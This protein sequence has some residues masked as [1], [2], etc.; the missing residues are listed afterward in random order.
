MEALA[1]AQLAEHNA[2]NR[3]AHL[4]QL[5]TA[6][7]DQ[8]QALLDQQKH[9]QESNECLVKQV[10]TTRARAIKIERASDKSNLTLSMIHNIVR[11]KSK[12]KP[13]I[14]NLLLAMAG[15]S[16]VYLTTVRCAPRTAQQLRIFMRSLLDLLRNGLRLG[17]TI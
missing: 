2:T 15:A 3:F 16:V 8:L 7:G 17:M 13:L 11:L 1:K 4:Q 6:Q 12:P 10:E 9:L 5:N 14:R